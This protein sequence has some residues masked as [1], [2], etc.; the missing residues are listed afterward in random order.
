[1]AT[2]ELGWLRLEPRQSVPALHTVLITR[3]S[4]RRS[5]AAEALGAFGADAVEALPDLQIALQDPDPHLS[6]AAKDAI[7]AIRTA[8]VP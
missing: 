4:W 1:M 7:R 8:Q 6:K 2:Q 5:L 3:D